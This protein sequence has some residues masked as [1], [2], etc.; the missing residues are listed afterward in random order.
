MTTRQIEAKAAAAQVPYTMARQI[1]QLLDEARK[2][3]GYSVD[4]W[5]EVERQIVEL[6][7]EEG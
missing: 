4:E 1:R 3:G 6:V 7:T 5:T 2:A